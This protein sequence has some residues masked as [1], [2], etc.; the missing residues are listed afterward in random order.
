MNIWLEQT[1]VVRRAEQNRLELE[2]QKGC[3]LHMRE[4]E[5]SRSGSA[6]IR[7]KGATLEMKAKLSR[8]EKLLKQRRVARLHKKLRLGCDHIEKQK[9]RLERS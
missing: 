7:A 6:E 8:P 9:G 1:R 2:K 4:E 5:Q 3:Q